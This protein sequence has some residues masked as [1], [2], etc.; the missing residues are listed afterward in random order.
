[1]E[2]LHMNS[3]NYKE[4]SVSIL[5]KNELTA[6]VKKRFDFDWEKELMCDVYKQTIVN[7]NSILGLMSVMIYEAEL[8]LE[9]KLLEVARENR[10]GRKS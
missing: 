7:D 5:Q 2:V 8:R 3:G 9:I 10:G 6:S 4:A 1:M